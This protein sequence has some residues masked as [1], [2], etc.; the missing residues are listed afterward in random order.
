LTTLFELTGTEQQ[1]LKGAAKFTRLKSVGRIRIK[2]KVEASSQRK[3]PQNGLCQ[4]S[5]KKDKNPD[6][7]LFLGRFL[8]LNAEFC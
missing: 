1:K 8:G 5:K 7:F 2:H 4:Q 6:K 3:L